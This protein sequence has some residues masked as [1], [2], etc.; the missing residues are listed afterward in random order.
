MTIALRSSLGVALA[1]LLSGIAAAAD[2]TPAAPAAA[3]KPVNTVC[4]NEGDPV[5]P[6]IAPVTV[7]MKDG[8]T[9]VIGVCCG[10]CPPIIAKDP[11]KYGA[12]ALKNQKAA[13]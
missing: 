10:K 8:K 11:E 12:A 7:T 13:E 6:S 9:V 3:A 4:P 1:L 5:D 2:A